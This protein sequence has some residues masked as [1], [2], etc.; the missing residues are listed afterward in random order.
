MVSL[1]IED[2]FDNAWWPAL[3]TQLRALNCPVNLHGLIR[4]YLYIN[5][6]SFLV[7]TYFDF[8]FASPNLT[9]RYLLNL[10][11]FNL[12][13]LGR[14]HSYVVCAIERY[15]REPDDNR[16]RP[17]DVYVCSRITQRAFE[18]LGCLRGAER[19]R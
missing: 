8:L 11:R 10:T 18:Y 9:N 15:L 5:Y 13:A 2:A 1:D 16:Q 17:T 3:E 7:G 19:F 6:I 4:G 12:L 14:K